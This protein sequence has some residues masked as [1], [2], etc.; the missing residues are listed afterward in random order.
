MTSTTPANSEL[1]ETG[2][3]GT[4]HWQGGPAHSKRLCYRTRGVFPMAPVL[5]PCTQATAC[6]ALPCICAVGAVTDTPSGKQQPWPGPA[7]YLLFNMC[8]TCTCDKD[9]RDQAESPA[10]CAAAAPGL[11]VSVGCSMSGVWPT[12]SALQGGQWLWCSTLCSSAWP[13]VAVEQCKGVGLR[14]RLAA[15]MTWSLCQR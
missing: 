6:F 7:V 5:A 1:P 4:V 12:T 11:S 10:C 2:A 8:H 13:P 3:M 14:E 9:S 15:A